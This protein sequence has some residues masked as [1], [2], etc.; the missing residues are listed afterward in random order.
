MANV[1]AAGV[2]SAPQT[3]PPPPHRNRAI[4]KIDSKQS[5][6]HEG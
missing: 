2:L 6:F 4:I 1:T 3:L 5:K